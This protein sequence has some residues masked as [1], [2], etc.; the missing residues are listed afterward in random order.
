MEFYNQHKVDEH[1][2]KNQLNLWRQR[3][4][5]VHQREI[6]R[7]PPGMAFLMNIVSLGVSQAGDLSDG[8]EP[9]MVWLKC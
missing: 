2:H 3:E 1:F 4:M 9:T 8:H 7:R 6:T 5:T